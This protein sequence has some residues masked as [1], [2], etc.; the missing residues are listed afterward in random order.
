[1]FGWF[2]VAMVRCFALKTIGEFLGGDLDRYVT[3]EAC[4]SGYRH[5][6]FTDSAPAEKKP[7]PLRQP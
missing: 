4:A 6:G 3:A 5:G 7:V 2:R 1:M